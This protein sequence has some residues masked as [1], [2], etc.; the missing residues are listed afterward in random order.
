MFDDQ[1]ECKKV[2]GSIAKLLLVR[3]YIENEVQFEF[4]KNDESCV[5]LKNFLTKIFGGDGQILNTLGAIELM[6]SGYAND[7]KL[8]AIIDGILESDLYKAYVKNQ[9]L[10]KKFCDHKKGNIFVAGKGNQIQ[11]NAESGRLIKDY[12]AI[13][14]ASIFSLAFN[15]DNDLIAC[16]WDGNI[17]LFSTSK[18]L[19]VLAPQK[20]AQKINGNHQKV[21]SIAIYDK[22]AF[23]SDE[24]GYLK[25]YNLKENFVMVCNFGQ[26]HQFKINSI[27]ISSDGKFIVTSD[28]G[29]HIKVHSLADK[30]LVES[31]EYAHKRAIF[32]IDIDKNNCQVSSDIKG[33][34]KKWD[35]GGNGKLLLI[36][37]AVVK[38]DEGIVYSQKINNGFVFVSDVGGNLKQFC[39]KSFGLMKDYGRVH[40]NVISGVW[41]CAG[42]LYTVDWGGV[43]KVI[44][45]KRQ[46]ILKSYRRETGEPIYSVIVN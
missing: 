13:H 33:I 34:L 45:V 10:A 23:I 26:I 14:S 3:S 46:L 16:D 39:L 31:I 42:R 44:D 40:K 18:N 4:L 9:S 2:I 41:F 20:S 17:K 6:L 12:G 5:C 25:Q 11:L 19:N 27:C 28:F 7:A 8:I 36:R 37:E 32:S 1:S 38:M 21:R 43:L 30:I 22:F 29:G 24:S 15:Q 35:L